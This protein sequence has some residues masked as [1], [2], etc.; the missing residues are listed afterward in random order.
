MNYLSSVDVKKALGANVSIVFEVCSHTVGGIL[1]DDMM[2]S[3]KYMV[4]FLLRHTK[5]VL[6]Q[7]QFDLRVGVVKGKL[8][9]YVQKWG[10]L[11]HAIVSNAEHLVP[12]D[13]AVNS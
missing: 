6:Y 5:V 9:G 1:H 12:A 11:S 10:S 7:G 2:K 8:A 3:V 4:E 13:Q